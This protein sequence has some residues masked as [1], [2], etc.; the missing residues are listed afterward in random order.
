MFWKHDQQL[1]FSY[2]VQY[3]AQPQHF[4]KALDY[5]VIPIPLE[6]S[7]DSSLQFFVH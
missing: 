2:K 6:L 5:I 3:L 7:P 1:Y 4:L